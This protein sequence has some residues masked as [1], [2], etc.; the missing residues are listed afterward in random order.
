M[1]PNLPP[2][3]LSWDHVSLHQPPPTSSAPQRAA[4][5]IEI[6]PAS[7]IVIPGESRDPIDRIALLGDGSRL[8]PG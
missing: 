7:F 4:M 5:E 8:S 3:Q 6:P 1:D 2:G